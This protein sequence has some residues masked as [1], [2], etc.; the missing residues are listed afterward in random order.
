MTAAI[1]NPSIKLR[2]KLRLVVACDFRHGVGYHYDALKSKK[3]LD[4]MRA[5]ECALLVSYTG[6]RVMFVFRESKT[7][8]RGGD[9]V[10]VLSSFHLNLDRHT[11]WSPLMIS[12]YAGHVGIDLIGIKRFEDHILDKEKERAKGSPQ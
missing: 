8:A 11:P 1:A 9:P 5:D 4:D 6:R 7:T 3:W 10:T 12:E 2:L